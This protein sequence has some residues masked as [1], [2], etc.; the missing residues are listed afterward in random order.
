MAAQGKVRVYLEV[1]SRRT[2]AAALDWPGWARSG[3][4]PQAALAALAEYSARYAGAVRPA[5]LGFEPPD[6]ASSFVIVERL[7]GD[8]TTDFGAPGAIP[9]LDHEPLVGKDVERQMALLRAAWAAMDGAVASARGKVLSTGPR[10]GG[11][12]LTQ[13]LKHALDADQAYL[14]SL[15]WKVTALPDDPLEALPQ[16]RDEVE[17]AVLASTR[18]EIAPIG[19]RG[20]KRWSA[21]TFIRRAAWHVLDH[22]WEIEDR[23]A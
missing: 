1:A 4:E 13:V 16:L 10:G 18:G 17:A 12:G 9:A 5:R 19:P 7:K 8:A 2:F 22:A 21:R 6:D 3:R 15:G 20:G 14:R 11:R 23:S